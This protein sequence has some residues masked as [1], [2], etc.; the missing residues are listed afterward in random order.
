MQVLRV[1]VVALM[2]VC[3]NM[4]YAKNETNVVA[5]PKGFSGAPIRIT[6]EDYGKGPMFVN[7][8]ENESTSVDAARAVIKKSGGVLVLLHQSKTR[9]L[10][11]TY[12]GKAYAVDPNRIYTQEGI[13]ASLKSLSGRAEKPVFDFVEDLGLQILTA[14]GKNLYPKH[15]VIVALH[16]NTEG[17]LSIASYDTTKPLRHGV[18]RIVKSRTADPDDFFLV[19]DTRLFDALAKDGVWNVVLQHSATVKDDGS[20]SVLAGEYKV[21]YLNIEAQHGHLSVQ[22]K[23]VKVVHGILTKGNGFTN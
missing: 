16:N 19:T 20:L 22:T 13:I 3:A 17:S 7:V 4:A 6:V 21:P 15:K 14:M 9:N 1:L 23:M 18:A 5:Y 10:N 8:H 11:F 2:F 12:H